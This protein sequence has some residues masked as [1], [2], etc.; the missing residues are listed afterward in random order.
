MHRNGNATSDDFSYITRAA[1]RESARRL[2][3]GL[4]LA[5]CSVRSASLQR[6]VQPESLDLVRLRLSS[7]FSPGPG[8]QSPGIISKFTVSVTVQ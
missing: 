5:D 7:N 1:R 4:R 3:P 2:G 8:S 6:Q